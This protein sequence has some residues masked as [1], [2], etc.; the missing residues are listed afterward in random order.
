MPWS[1][2]SEM[3]EQFAAVL[4]QYEKQKGPQKAVEIQRKL[5][6][7][8]KRVVEDNAALLD[9]LPERK[10]SITL[11]TLLQKTYRDLIDDMNEEMRERI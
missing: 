2:G 5:E 8:E 9:W 4:Q 10:R 6:D 11:E 7:A 3:K 1:G